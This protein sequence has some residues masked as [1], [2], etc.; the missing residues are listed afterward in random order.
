MQVTFKK[1]VQAWKDVL[2]RGYDPENLKKYSEEFHTAASKVNK[3]GT[4]L[5]VEVADA[6]VRL[7]PAGM[8]AL[9]TWRSAP[10]GAGIPAGNGDFPVAGFSI[11][12]GR[13]AD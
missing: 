3:M 8:P 4:S 7:A 10:R 13:R 1:Q 12:G 2:L 11:P 5:K 6:D 9:Q